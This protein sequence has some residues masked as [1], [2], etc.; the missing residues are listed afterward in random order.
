MTDDMAGSES[1]SV[2]VG[3]EKRDGALGGNR[4]G[5]R[6]PA[7]VTSPGCVFINS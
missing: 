6:V 1:A 7:E 4:I 5:V 3:G 2:L